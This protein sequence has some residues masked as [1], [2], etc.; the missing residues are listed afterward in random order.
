MTLLQTTISS[1][2]CWHYNKAFIITASVHSPD[3]KYDIDDNTGR[4]S[5]PG[6]AN[7]KLK[8]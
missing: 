1:Y 2:L 7:V 6:I 3:V 5:F 4:H 8:C